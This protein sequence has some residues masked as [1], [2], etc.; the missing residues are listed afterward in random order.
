M[1]VPKPVP[2]KTR[3][4]AESPCRGTPCGCPSPYPPKRANQPNPPV[5]A[6]LVGAQPRLPQTRQPAI[7][8]V[9]APLVGA[10]FS[11]RRPFASLR[12]PRAVKS[13]PCPSV[14]QKRCC[15]S[16]CRAVEQEKS[17]VLRR[18]PV[19]GKRQQ[20]PNSLPELSRQTWDESPPEQKTPANVRMCLHRLCSKL[21]VRRYSSGTLLF[22]SLSINPIQT[23][24][25][26]STRVKRPAITENITRVVC[27]AA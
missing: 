21:T 16:S 14:D 12:G 4:P 11:T 10:L 7:S 24:A 5:G 23:C 17:D 13:S 6:P 27:A 9:G 2:P 1:W 15:H 3:Q 22:H 25:P 18:Y 8:P 19:S 20:T 26:P